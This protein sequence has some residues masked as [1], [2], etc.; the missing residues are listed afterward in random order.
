MLLS[1]SF[2][3]VVGNEEDKRDR[4]EKRSLFY[5]T[6]HFWRSSLSTFRKNMQNKLQIRNNEIN[7][8]SEKK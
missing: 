1:F 7:F 5:L 2:I 8:C 6:T 4:K 3:F